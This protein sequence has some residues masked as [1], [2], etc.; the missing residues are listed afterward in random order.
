[1]FKPYPADPKSIERRA[2]FADV[3]ERAAKADPVASSATAAR[4]TLRSV[5][6]YNGVLPIR[7]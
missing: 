5:P 1:M 4:D 7:P 6:R 2:R 3:C